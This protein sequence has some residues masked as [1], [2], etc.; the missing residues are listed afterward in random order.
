M[1]GLQ[2]MIL[3]DEIILQSKIA[4]RAAARLKAIFCFS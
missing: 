1:T 3:I 2:E 4:Q